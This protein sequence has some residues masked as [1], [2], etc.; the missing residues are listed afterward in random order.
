LTG[1]DGEVYYE[2]NLG[3]VSE[4]ED[5]IADKLSFENQGIDLEVSIYL[6]RPYYVVA[7]SSG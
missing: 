3:P 6:V 5:I 7:C 2:G 4:V 1:C